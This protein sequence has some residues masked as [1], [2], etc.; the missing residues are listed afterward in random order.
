MLLGPH[1]IRAVEGENEMPSALAHEGFALTLPS[2]IA[3]GKGFGSWGTHR[4]MRIT[5]RIK[6]RRGI[7][8]QSLPSARASNPTGK[9]G[10]IVILCAAIE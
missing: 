4:A 3:D 7:V 1:G 2:L 10:F 6:Y 5:G 9:H 8:L